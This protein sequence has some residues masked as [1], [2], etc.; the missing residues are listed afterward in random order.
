M[1]RQTDSAIVIMI[2]EF[3]E[4]G[5]NNSNNVLY[6]R[7]INAKYN[8]MSDLIDIVVQFN[9][10][11]YLTDEPATYAQCVNMIEKT[12]SLIRTVSTKSE[13]EREHFAYFIDNLDE[14]KS[15]VKK[16]KQGHQLTL[17]AM[18]SDMVSKLTSSLEL[19]KTISIGKLG[20]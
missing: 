7:V 6:G 2:K 20:I 1:L 17:V 19:T 10:V 16:F 14:M 4:F 8:S 15:V 9:Q 13:T 5:R 18:T 3:H 12:I 11:H